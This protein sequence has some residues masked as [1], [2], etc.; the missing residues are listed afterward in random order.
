MTKTA[1]S[2]LSALQAAENNTLQ[3]TKALNATGVSIRTLNKTVE[4]N[5]TLFVRFDK[6][7]VQFG[8]SHIRLA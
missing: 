6:P 1:Q 8:A 3:I 5:P 7:G 4:N 2:L